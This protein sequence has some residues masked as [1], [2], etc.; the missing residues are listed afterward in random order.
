MSA[1][2]FTWIPHLTSGVFHPGTTRKTQN[3]NKQ[4]IEKSK[5][6]PATNICARLIFQCNYYYRKKKSKHK[7]KTIENSQNQNSSNNVLISCMPQRD[8][9]FFIQ[10][11]INIPKRKLTQKYIYV[12]RVFHLDT[13]Y[14]VRNVSSWNNSK[15]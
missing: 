7:Q 9:N 4:Q 3:I 1:G 10:M 6:I 15:K 2:C 8:E 5:R 14:Y 11:P 13:P 12:S